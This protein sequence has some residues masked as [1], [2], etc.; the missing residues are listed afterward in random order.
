MKRRGDVGRDQNVA[1]YPGEKVRCE[2]LTGV[3]FLYI[4]QLQG[5]YIY[6]D[7]NVFLRK[8]SKL[9][10]GGYFMLNSSAFPCVLCG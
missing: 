4:H 7:R 10:A 9:A 8:I 5:V 6:M 3:D 2:T 1:R